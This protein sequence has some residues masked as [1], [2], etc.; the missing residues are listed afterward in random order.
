MAF[1]SYKHKITY[2]SVPKCA[3][4]S[5]KQ[6]AFKLENGRPLKGFKINGETFAIHQM[7]R[8]ERFE[9]LP[10]SQI[11]G[12]AKYAI[13]RHPVARIKS[14]YES[15]VLGKKFGLKKGAKA[16][17]KNAGL[18]LMPSFEEFI[19]KLEDYQKTSAMLR[20]H[21]LPLKYFMGEDGA[22]Y[23]RIFDISELSE[24]S[25]WIKERCGRDVKLRHTNKGSERLPEGALTPALEAKICK[26][27]ASDLEI[28]GQ[29]I[30]PPAKA[31]AQELAS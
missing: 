5:G 14:C 25:G 15:K 31:L 20:K 27:F 10:H 3:C 24:L 23:D 21:T 30:K 6:F 29:W 4:T 16:K 7:V 12:H 26:M 11:K 28:F 17:F 8:S 18:S 2:V 19:D 1:H 9:D 13:V 22:W